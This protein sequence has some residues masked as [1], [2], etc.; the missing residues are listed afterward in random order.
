M[1]LPARSSVGNPLEQTIH[2]WIQCGPN[3]P[4]GC[5]RNLDEPGA[6]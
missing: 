4:D 5:V 2:T 3:L 1:R 6:T